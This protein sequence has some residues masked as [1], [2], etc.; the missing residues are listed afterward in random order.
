MSLTLRKSVL[1][2][3]HSNHFIETGTYI[4]GGVD[5]AL[6]CGYQSIHS[7]E[8]SDIYYN[9]CVLKFKGVDSVHLYHGDST[10]ILPHVLGIITDPCTL[11]LDGHKIPGH[12][13]TSSDGVGWKNCPILFE[14]DAI[15]AHPIKTHTILIDDLHAFGTP[16]LDWIT[17]DELKT[18]LEAINPN[19]ILSFEHGQYPHDILV[20]HI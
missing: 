8:M 16:I 4:G 1:N 10:V 14:L 17:L 11:W 6:E 20:A 13:Y 7:I 18:K 2:K 19:Y 9:Q 12:K 15:A 5:L 3:Y